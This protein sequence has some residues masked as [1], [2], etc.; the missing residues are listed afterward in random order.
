MNTKNILSIIVAAAILSACGGDPKQSS[1]KPKSLIPD[2][3]QFSSASS[4]AS[5]EPVSS[6]V[7]EPLPFY[8]SFNAENTRI[9][10]SKDYKAL[11]TH[12]DLSFYHATG[13]FGAN[14]IPEANT[15]SWLTA[16]TDRKLRLSNARFTIGQ[17]QQDNTN[18]TVPGT[19]NIIPGE[20]D[21]SEPYTISFCVNQASGSGNLEVYIDNNTTGGN[22]SLH[23]SGN[24]SRIAQQQA[25]TLAV[26]QRFS[27][28]IPNLVQ[29]KQIGTANSFIQMRVSS[30]GNVVFDDLIIE[31]QSKPFA[32][33]V[34]TCVAED[35]ID[36]APEVAPTAPAVT[37]L[38]GD[39]QLTATWGASGVGTTYEVF[40]NIVNS[41]D[42]ATAYEGNPVAGTS[43]AITGLVN[44]QEYFVW[45]RA[46]N[47]VGSSDFSDPVSATPVAPTGVDG[48][49]AW[50]FNSFEYAE[51]LA[52]TSG[53]AN[54]NTSETAY[55]ADGLNIF[56]NS[57]TALRYRFDSNAWNFNGNSYRSTESRVPAVGETAEE[58]RAYISVP[59]VSGRAVEV[60]FIVKQTGS[61]Q[62]GKAV[63][64]DQLNKVIL[65]TEIS[66]NTLEVP[67]TV[68]LSEGHNTEALRVF[69]SR[70]GTSSGGMDLVSLRKSYADSPL[71]E[72]PGSS[73][74]SS[75]S[76]VS[77][78]SSSS[79]SVAS[80]ET[81]SES[82]VASSSETSSSSSS[83]EASSEASS[84]SSS[85]SSE[86]NGGTSSESSSSSS[87]AAS[88]LLTEAF[89]AA[90]TATFF[91]ADYKAMPADAGKA[92]YRALAGE[93]RIT[94]SDGQLSLNNARFS[95]G[96]LSEGVATTGSAQ[97]NGAFDL[98]QPYRIKFTILAATGTGNFQVYVDNNTTSA[99]NSIHTTTESTTVSRLL[100]VS[101]SS[102]TSF[103]Y[104]VVIE[105]SVGTPNSFFQIRADSNITNLVI[106]NLVIEYQ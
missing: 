6:T 26:G 65:V 87:V 103:P 61:G 22:N 18:V 3:F 46:K 10:F 5:S 21:L 15:T 63:V 68:P 95:I 91:S 70:E 101:P 24:A 12:P 93:S 34:P 106:D 49:K 86:L 85:S 7:N 71:E 69:Y 28:S 32:G 82:S 11:N 78:E 67:L 38:V 1:D 30:G 35:G 59:V 19:T 104:D 97:P 13:G 79:S 47:A 8:E 55:D 14:Y 84:E 25:S 51:F 54:V 16:N 72:E 4:S 81:S 57:G 90:D 99:G 96:D 31:T 36:P 102:I 60:S 56:L 52:A 44:G 33:T 89:T 74:S 42:G 20:F 9:F 62:I 53:T 41:V 23:G 37:L 92:L 94:L 48:S 98:S 29:S 77:S 73:S 75:D 80:S 105:S 27:V 83:S 40:Y 100:Q 43:V 2:D 64:V 39:A 76:S 45:V 66:D 50:G 88:A 58:L 17:T